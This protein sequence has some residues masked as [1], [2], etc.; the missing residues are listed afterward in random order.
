MRLNV[1]ELMHLLSILL[2]MHPKTQYGLPENNQ[3]MPPKETHEN[4]AAI[5][6]TLFKVTVIE[7]TNSSIP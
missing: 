2:D 6:L 5:M 7:R 4:K 1:I 3:P